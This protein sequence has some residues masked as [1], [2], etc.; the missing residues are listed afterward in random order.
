[1]KNS[2]SSTLSI[3][4]HD[5]ASGYRHIQHKPRSHIKLTCYNRSTKTEKDEEH[6]T[7]SIYTI[8]LHRTNAR[9]ARTGT[10]HHLRTASALSRRQMQSQLLQPT[11]TAHR[12]PAFSTMY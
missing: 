1:M 6:E 8:D 12:H 10:G 5:L 9:L 7:R 11:R 3:I 4:T 2:I